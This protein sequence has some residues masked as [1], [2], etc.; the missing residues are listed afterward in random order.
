MSESEF[1]PH[2][3]SE[4]DVKM[5]GPGHDASHYISVPSKQLG[6]G[7]RPPS[8]RGETPRKEA[9]EKVR[10]PPTLLDGPGKVGQ[11]LDDL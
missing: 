11:S 9:E 4:G 5:V 6:S 7:I 10:P 1:R 2:V 3:V 8:M